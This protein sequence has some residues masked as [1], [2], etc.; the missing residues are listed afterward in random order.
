[1]A[2]SYAEKGFLLLLVLTASVT[3]GICQER[4]IVVGGSEGWRFGFNYTDWSIQNSPFY[5]ND[6]LVFKY[7]P[8]KDPEYAYSIYLL[9]TL[10][11]YI[12]CNF[13]GAELLANAT[14]GAG[15]GFQ[16][17]LSNWRPY[18]FASYG[19]D[20]YHCNDGLMKVVA[21]PWPQV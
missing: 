9:P 13:T 20:G 5:I 2:L 6:K 17:E 19:D 1:M 4:T 3:L 8:P 7:D 12:A 14:E 21:V 16:V 15:D 11:S 10:D 18:Y